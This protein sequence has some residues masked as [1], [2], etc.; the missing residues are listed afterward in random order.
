MSRKLYEEKSI[1]AIA[2]AIREKNGS[3]SKYKVGEMASAI[4]EIETGTE[5][6]DVSW[7]QCPLLP[8]NFVNDVT[9]DS[10]DYTVSQIDSNAPA[11]PV[12]SNY[13]PIG[14]TVD[15]VTFYNEIPNVETP[16]QTAESYGTLKPIDPVRYINTPRAPNVRDLG[17]WKCDGG[18][19][20]YGMLIRGGFCSE[21][22]REVL[23]AECGI[24]HDLDLRGTAEAGLSASPL[25]N[26]IYYT[27]AENYAWYSLVNQATWRTNL[28][29]VFDAVTH[30]EPL[31]FHCSAGADRT[32]TLACVL[33]GLLGMSQSDIDK[34]YELTCFYTGRDTDLTAR[35]RNEAEWQGL[36]GEISAKDGETF[37]DKCVTFVA[38]LGFTA[39][40][41][42]AYR[43]ALIEGSPETVTPTVGTYTVTQ[44]LTNASSGNEQNAATEYQPYTAEIRANDGFVIEKVV[45]KMNG[46]VITS[47]AWSGVETNLYRTVTYTLENCSASGEKN[48]IDGQSFVATLT[49]ALNYTLD[50]ADVKITMG[51]EDMS[52][53]YSGGVIAIEKVTGNIEIEVTAIESGTQYENL[54]PTSL[55]PGGSTVYNGTGYK[56]DSRW[57]AGTTVEC[58][59]GTAG[60]VFTTGVIPMETGDVL[61]FVNC[62]IDPNATAET[63]GAAASSMRVYYNTVDDFM[64]RLVNWAEMAMISKDIEYNDAGHI[65][66]FT[67]APTSSKTITS[68]HM[69]LAGDGS[70][71]IV[72]KG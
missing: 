10:S 5:R 32:G 54:I 44:T 22:D 63:Y 47:G 9:Y 71:A 20:K 57:V 35:R 18:T 49:A 43:A 24:R 58:N 42:N 67:F 11:T 14:E 19:V 37:R 34:D 33:E 69:T 39:E 25:G 15:G 3:E 40:E 17:G 30:G 16:F 45:V 59:G 38:E 29:C 62:W 13:K 46:N 72:Y 64:S 51:G 53:Y 28:R 50:G 12:V 61:K 26:D 68:I 1:A 56:Q 48:V 27:C 60:R 70:K 31:Y 4:G 23:C 7:H 52:K 6:K 65:I 21:D 41:I 55:K 36:I 66:G 8:R 2:S